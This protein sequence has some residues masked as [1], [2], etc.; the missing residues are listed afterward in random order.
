MD[1]NC[2]I[3]SHPAP[4]KNDHQLLSL[5]HPSN[6]LSTPLI[7]FRFF[8]FCSMSSPLNPLAPPFV[9]KRHRHSP[10]AAAADY[11]DMKASLAAVTSDN[12]RLQCAVELMDK[13][14]DRYKALYKEVL[15]RH[16]QLVG[17]LA[18]KEV[19]VS[20]L[21]QDGTQQ[22]ATVEAKLAY[23]D[24]HRLELLM[25][26]SIQECTIERLAREGGLMYAKLQD[27]N[28]HPL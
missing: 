28:L 6:S 16:H 22:L 12:S 17:R 15:C 19:Q 3:F 23:S 1:K 13:K 27:N 4:P 26:S 21:R 10:A 24:K 5:R 2:H 18:E 8:C 7:I 14:L 9:A 11:Q 25:R 20:T